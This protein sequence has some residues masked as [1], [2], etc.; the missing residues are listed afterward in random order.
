MIRELG[1]DTS[2]TRRM[3]NSPTLIYEMSHNLKDI[4]SEN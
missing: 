1:R 4:K 2:E 3:K